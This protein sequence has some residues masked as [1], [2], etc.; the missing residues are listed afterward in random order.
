VRKIWR[1]STPLMPYTSTS[2]TSPTCSRSTA[3]RHHG[4]TAFGSQVPSQRGRRPKPALDWTACAAGRQAMCFSQ[5]PAASSQQRAPRVWLPTCARLCGAPSAVIGGSRSG[6]AWRMV[7]SWCVCV[8]RRTWKP[9]ARATPACN[10]SGF[11]VSFLFFSPLV[12]RLLDSVC[13]AVDPRAPVGG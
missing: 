10:K 2:R 7:L 4:T 9:T 8:G 1:G 13:V 6:N 11:S 12:E 5:Q 3:P